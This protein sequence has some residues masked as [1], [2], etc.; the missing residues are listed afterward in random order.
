MNE[1]WQSER[2]S[3][4]KQ[5]YV[6]PDF[7]TVQDFLDL[8]SQLSHVQHNAFDEVVSWIVGHDG[9]LSELKQR[10]AQLSNEFVLATPD[11]HPLL[12]TLAC[13]A[14]LAQAP[15]AQTWIRVSAYKYNSWQLA[16]WLG[17]AMMAYSTVHSSA[18]EAY[19]QLAK[20]VFS[21][22]E[23]FSIHSK[24]D[25]TNSERT[26][27]WA[28][29]NECRSKLDEIW[30]E[31]RGWSGFM[32]YESEM[33]LFEVFYELEPGEFIETI[34]K[35]ANPY[36]V[37]ALLVAARIGPFASKFSD[38]Q[39]MIAAAPKAFEDDGTWNHSVLMPLLLVEARS[40]LLQVRQNLRSPDLES[41]DLGLIKD[42]ITR[43]AKLIANALAGRSDAPAI[44]AR[45][46]PWLM[47]Q[48]LLARSEKEVG[49]VTSAA[50]AD[51]TLI[52]MIGSKLYGSSLP[53]SSPN[54][55]STWEA[56][57]YRCVLVSFA[58]NGHIKVPDWS[59]FVDEW[60]ISPDDWACAK[61][62]LLRERASLVTGLHK[63]M[64][65]IAANF[66][67]YP[68]TQST[69]PAEY[70]IGLWNNAVTLREI[71]EFGDPDATTD[72]YNS[73]SEAGRLLLL[74]FRVGLA[75]FDQCAARYSGNVSPDSRSIARLF[76]ALSSA[77]YEMREIDSTLNQDAWGTIAQ[78][79]AV[80]RMIWA[81]PSSSERNSTKYSNVFE[82][83]DTPSV[84]DILAAS[85][86]DV[87]ELAGLLQSLSLNDPDGS[88]V[89]G[90][91]NSALI[92]MPSIVQLVRT[93]NQYHP[94]KYPVNEA[95]LQKLTSL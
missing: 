71:V 74:L 11:C 87:I 37:S 15:V 45:W 82:A 93:L 21:G 47:R 72:E 65:G 8:Q 58:Y 67:A 63:E 68:I 43:S 16:R 13:A 51:D 34:S 57:C 42:E 19:V 77:N 12:M 55:A 27:A 91:L 6:D 69:S 2:H 56:W 52:D 10:T 20:Q 31:L 60:D 17:N 86:G 88:I 89:K 26:G 41:V 81:L 36:L 66:L 29:W 95:Q 28:H 78:H 79:L 59:S 38:W 7:K 62:H 75:T 73:R 46:T 9:D 54:D 76:S 40:Q 39:R 61:G 64:P 53:Q 90:F 23:D 18:C 70:W 30:W 83:N 24:S 50:F 85:K 22:L 48:I 35:C 3:K 4:A 94:R 92:D 33:P 49:D 84:P 25:R 32:N 5:V 80:R 1:Q 44:F 14:A